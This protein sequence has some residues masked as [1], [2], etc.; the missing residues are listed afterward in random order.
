MWIIS[1]IKHIHFDHISVLWRP[2]YI[3]AH[4]YCFIN[5]AIDFQDF[6][7]LK[8]ALLLIWNLNKRLTVIGVP[9]SQPYVL[10]VLFLLHSSDIQP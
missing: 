9:V 10:F 2:N 7:A 1:S 5:L 6:P 4:V 3:I 8:S